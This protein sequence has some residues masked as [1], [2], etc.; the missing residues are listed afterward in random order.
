MNAQNVINLTWEGTMTKATPKLTR[1]ELLKGK[2]TLKDGSEFF[3]SLP[4]VISDAKRGSEANPDD[5]ESD[6]HRQKF[7]DPEGYAKNLE[8][9]KKICA[10][11]EECKTKDKDGPHFI[12]AWRMYPNKDHPRWQQQE[13]YSCACGAGGVC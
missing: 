4:A 6:Y 3:Q 12:L 5:P 8:L 10:A 9:A 13:P 1:E 11:F 2:E 7:F